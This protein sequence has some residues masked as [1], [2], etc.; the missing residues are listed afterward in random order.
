M[1]VVTPMH[2]PTANYLS[3]TTVLMVPAFGDR[4]VLLARHAWILAHAV[5]M[6]L[7][8]LENA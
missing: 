1:A 3:L 4:N 7:T 5:M 8:E 2:T 6:E